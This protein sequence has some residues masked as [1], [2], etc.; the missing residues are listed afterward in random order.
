MIKKNNN[1][2]KSR[3][4]SKRD[5]KE[6]KIVTYIRFCFWS[7][8]IFNHTCGHSLGIEAS[9]KRLFGFEKIVE[10]LSNYLI[11]QKENI[12]GRKRMRKES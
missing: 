6:K 5:T 12:E 8:W 10:H 11:R 4:G 9:T 3:S 7:V 2:P 1:T